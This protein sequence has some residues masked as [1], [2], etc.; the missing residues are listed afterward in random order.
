MKIW[1]AVI[2]S[3]LFCGMLAMAAPRGGA[4]HGKTATVAAPD[5][6]PA[7]PSAVCTVGSRPEPVPPAAGH[8]ASHEEDPRILGGSRSRSERNGRR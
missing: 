1:M 7:V 3:C 6:S 8:A 4:T 2:A 5:R